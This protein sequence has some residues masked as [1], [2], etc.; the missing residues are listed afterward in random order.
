[1]TTALVVVDMQNAFCLPSGSFA[2]RGGE[3]IGIGDVIAGCQRLIE[4]A[5]AN[6]WWVVCT[7]MTFSSDYREAGLLVR[8]RPAIREKGA[9]LEGSVDARIV[10]ALLPLP[11]GSVIHRKT[12]YDPFCNTSLAESLKDRG[13]EDVVVCGVLTNVC[14]EST[15]RRAYDLDFPVRIVEDA[16]SSTRADLHA[17]SLETMS[18]HF[19]TRVLIEDVIGRDSA[20]SAKSSERSGAASWRSISS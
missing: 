14:V 19:A 1:M 3:V 15:V 8:D 17:A 18:R 7:A 13:V 10:E 12:R 2:Q 6:D 5:E 4:H 11:P 16:M 20:P 9:Y